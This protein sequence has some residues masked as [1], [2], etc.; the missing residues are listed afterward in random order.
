M[1]NIK[2]TAELI[3]AIQIME[4]EQAWHLSRIREKFDLTME[5]LRPVN[6]V[7]NSLKEI[8]SSPNLFKNILGIAAGLFTGYLSN[9]VILLG[10]SNNKYRRVFG[11][12]LQFGVAGIV[13]RGPKV[14]KSLGNFISQRLS[15]KRNKIFTVQ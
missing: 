8:V 5:S 7:G 4:A 3:E 9:K 12:V 6:L 13:A 15:R 1:E 2:S 11:K 14:I 10:A